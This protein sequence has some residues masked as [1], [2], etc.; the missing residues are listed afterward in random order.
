MEGGREGEGGREDGRR[1]TRSRIVEFCDE[2][3]LPYVG[4]VAMIA[5]LL[6]LAMLFNPK[7]PPLSRL[8]VMGTPS[9]GL[10]PIGECSGL[11]DDRLRM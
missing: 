3:H 6:W 5:A 10:D 11:D 9:V 8:V 4:L 2:L 7:R 1:K